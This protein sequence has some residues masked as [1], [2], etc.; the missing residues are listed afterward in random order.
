MNRSRYSLFLLSLTACGCLGAAGL[1]TY[2]LRHCFEASGLLLRGSHALLGLMIF[3]TVWVLVT[4][5]LC[6][7]LNALPGTDDCFSEGVGWRC[8]GLAALLLVLAGS[9]L[10]LNGRAK[11][12]S[13]FTT[14][15]VLGGLLSAACLAGV[16]CARRRLGENGFWLSLLPVIFAL[17]R[18]IYYF[19]GWSRDPMVIDFA[20]HL[21][22]SISGVL[23]LFFLTGYPLK[24]GR[25]RSTVFWS[26]C[27]AVFT[28]M[29]IPDA[30]LRPQQTPLSALLVWLGLCLWCLCGAGQILREC[31]QSETA[32][33][34]AEEIP[35]EDGAEPAP[36]PVEEEPSGDD[37]ETAP[38]R[39]SAQTEQ[40][41]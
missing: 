25:R 5:M 13:S 12:G 14:I 28:A 4:A 27:C 16:A 26:L 19:R 31:V 15:L 41:D 33:E 36:E 11:D 3:S 6:R 32:P 23:A 20:P 30:I 1:R 17:S 34:P 22:A 2:I 24:V 37:A 40:T 7:R 35:S 21:M 10:A 8:F 29:M 9:I 18:L 39:N 38:S